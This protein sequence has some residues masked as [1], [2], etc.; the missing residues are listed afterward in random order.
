ML[1]HH[2]RVSMLSTH[3]IKPLTSSS[4]LSNQQNMHRDSSKA[5]PIATLPRSI[6]REKN[7]SHYPLHEV[8]TLFSTK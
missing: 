2:L 8:L 6:H 1:G 3:T 7:T 4:P 5:V